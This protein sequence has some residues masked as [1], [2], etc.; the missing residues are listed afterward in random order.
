MILLFFCWVKDEASDFK[1]KYSSD[2]AWALILKYCSY[3]ERCHAEVRSRLY[4]YGLPTPE[5]EENISRL[6]ENNYLNELRF[7]CAFA[8]GK[9]KVKKWGRVKIKIELKRRQIS[10]YC[11]KKAL[12]EIDE[13]IYLE[14]LTELIARKRR[15]YRGSNLFIQNRKVANYC[16]AKGYEGDLV[17]DLVLA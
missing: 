7:S 15:D 2:E 4:Q 6:I 5:V 1:K 12:S 17:W 8:R 11:I 3:Q 9:F 13:E 14:V 10:E 16:M